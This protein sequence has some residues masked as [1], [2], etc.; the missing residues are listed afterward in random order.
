MNRSIRT[1]LTTAALS[2]GTL[3]MAGVAHAGSDTHLSISVSGYGQPQGYVAPR[4]YP[5]SA[6]VYIHQDRPQHHVYNDRHVYD[7]HVYDRHVYND[8]QVYN[9]RHAYYEDRR[10]H[11]RAERCGAERWNPNVRYSP[12]EVVWRKGELYVARP[13]SNR[14]FNENS[15][16][17][18]TP[19]YWAPARCR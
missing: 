15:P 8:R 4:P 13:I 11:R 16:P 19:N 18:W 14:V 5:G 7:R 6:P 17:E 3:G 12:G 10:D 2:V 1:L 9:D